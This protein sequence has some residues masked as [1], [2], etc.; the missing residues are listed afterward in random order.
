ML[1][2]YSR[3]SLIV[4]ALSIVAFPAKAISEKEVQDC[5]CKGLRQEVVLKSG[6]RADC[7]TDTHA[8]E[9]DPTGKWAEALGQSLHYANETSR[10]P[11]I[12]LFCKHRDRSKCLKHLLRLEST[13]AAYQLD[14][15]INLHDRKSIRDQCPRD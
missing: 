7:I 3:L 8:V 2:T 11:R 13:I 5:V 10:K 1:A 4:I 9:V 14:V 12:V 15:D 6:A